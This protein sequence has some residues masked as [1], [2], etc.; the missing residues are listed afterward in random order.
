M[1]A[2]WAS[3]PSDFSFIQVI[4]GNTAPNPNV[5]KPQSVSGRRS[6][7]DQP[8]ETLDPLRDELRMLDDVALGVKHAGHYDLAVRDPTIFHSC[9]C[10][11]LRPRRNRLRTGYLGSP[12]SL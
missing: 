11:A 6:P 8:G 5:P 1:L 9:A 2:I 4:G 12:R 7:F 10:A 3:S